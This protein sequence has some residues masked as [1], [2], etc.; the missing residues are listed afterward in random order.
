MSRVESEFATR[1]TEARRRRG[2][3]PGRV[4]AECARLG[5]DALDATAIAAIETGARGVTAAE[6]S[7]LALALGVPVADLVPTPLPGPRPPVR[8]PRP[9]RSGPVDFFISYSLLDD[10]WATWIAHE[11]ESAGYEVM[12]Q[13]WDFVPGTHFLDF[14]DRGIRESSAVIAVLSSNYLASQYGRLEWMAAMQAAHDRPD[15]KLLLPVR[16]Q[17]IFP[18]GLLGQVTFVDLVGIDEPSLARA[19][20]LDRLEHALTGRAK[21]GEHPRFPGAAVV[22]ESIPAPRASQQDDHAASEFPPA[23]KPTGSPRHEL[24]IL[25][26]PGP[27]FGRDSGSPVDRLAALDAGLARLAESGLPT[28][29]LVV[30]SG[31]LTDSGSREQFDQVRSFLI[32]LRSLLG[33]DAGRLVVVPGGGDITAAACE[34]YFAHCRAESLNPEPPYFSKWLHYERLHRELYPGGNGTVFD[35]NQPW[36]LVEVA[37][38]R[39]VVAAFNSTVPHTHQN[40]DQ[41]GRLGADQLAWF[42]A[43]L[44]PFVESGHLRIGVVGHTP[45]AEG[46]AALADAAALDNALGSRLNLLLSGDGPGS[47]EVGALA[48]G[49]TLVPP[50]GGPR[51]LHLTRDGVD[52]W[53]LVDG[54]RRVG[55]ARGPWHAAAQTFTPPA[56][57]GPRVR[58]NRVRPADEA[59]SEQ[60]VDQLLRRI[61]EVLEVRHPGAAVRRLPGRPP[62]LRVSYPDGDLVPQFLIAAHVGEPTAAD[63]AALATVR[64]RNAEDLTSELVYQGPNPGVTLRAAALRDGIRLRSFIEFQGL[65]DLRGYVKAQTERLR[66]DRVYPPELYVPQRFR[67]TEGAAAS[68]AGVRED[69]VGELVD[70]LAAD[71]GRF[72]LLM[73]D[74]GRGKTF[75]MRT[76]AMTLPAKLPGVSPIL[77]ELHALD[78]AHSVDGLVAAHL[79][80]HGESRID[81]RAFRYL[82]RQG[83]VVLLF[84]GFDE[85]ASRVS[86][87]RA[88]EH[89]TTLLAAA[90]DRAKIVVTS[91]TQHFQNDDQVRTALGQQVGALAQRRILL[92]EDFT[93]QQVDAYVANRYANDEEVARERIELINRVDDLGGLSRNPRMLSF[94]VGLDAERLAAVAARDT[95][96]AASLYEEIL[97]SWLTHEHDRA[98]P[99]G[100]QAGLTLPEMWSAVTTLA[101]R[102]WES[103]DVLLRLDDVAEV[104]EALAGLAEAP[105]SPQ[106]ATH[107]VGA[108]SLLVRT[109][110]GLFGFIHSSVAEYLLAREIA[111]QLATGDG[112]PALLGRRKLSQPTVDFLCDLA[113]PRRLLLWAARPGGDPVTAANALKISKRLSAPAKTDMREA[114]LRGEDLSQRDLSGV[115]LT[116]ADLT[117][118]LLIGTKLSRA[119]L[120][121]AR[122]HRTRLDQAVLRDADLTDADLTGARLVETDLRGAVVTGSTWARAAL[123]NVDADRELWAAPEL[124]AAAVAPGQPVLTGLRPA[125]V[126]VQFGFE[127]GRLPSPLAYSPDGSL[128]AVGSGDGGVLLCDTEKGLPLRTLNGHLDRVYAVDFGPPGSALVTAAADG[129]VRFWDPATGEQTKVV[130]DGVEHTAP[131]WPLLISPDGGLVAY[132]DNAGTVVVRTVPAGEVVHRFDGHV[133]RVWALAFHPTDP[134]LATADESGAVRLWDL[135]TGAER[136]VLASPGSAVYTLSF[137]ADGRL[138]A[139]AGQ[140]AY[141]RVWDVQ[142]GAEAHRL[143]GHTE[144]VYAAVF[145]PEHDVLASGDTAGSVR[146][147]TVPRH[148]RATGAPLQHRHATAVYHLAFSPDGRTLAS[149]DSDG[150]LRVWDTASGQETHEV[151]AH[152][153]AV[154]P[155]A[156][157]ADSAQ[158]A[159]TGRDGAI[160]LWDPA[161]GRQRHELHGHGRRVV[162]VHF[163]RDGDLLAAAGNDG[164]VRVWDPGTGR[165]LRVL[166]GR[167]DQLTG[168]VFNPVRP[169][170][171]T[172]SNDGGVHL[173]HLSTW[174]ADQEL[175]VETEYVWA[176]AF[177]PDGEVLAT[178]NDDDTVRLWWQATGR[179]VLALLEHRGRVRSIVFSPDGSLV[180]TGCDD[181]KVRLFDRET[182]A[183]LATLDGHTDRV[184]DVRFTADGRLLASV[185]NDGTAVLW[186]VADHAR[187]RVLPA[188]RGKLWCCAFSPDGRVLA[189]AGD[190]A[191]IYL[192]DTET[193]TSLARMPGHS[194]RVLSLAFSP[195]GT[196]LASGSA[197]G[198][199]RLWNI[200]RRT[201]G[202]TMIGLPEAWAAVTPDGRYK[203]DGPPSGE[204]WHAV[205]LCRFEVGEL[206]TVLREVR[207]VP[208][209]E[210][211]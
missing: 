111:R 23:T 22:K 24:G 120:R 199:T 177:A 6:V 201:L 19:R 174:R 179:E 193:G 182:G 62:V 109:E 68:D 51:L 198:T 165:Q 140:H 3:S 97:T 209:T 164:V 154:W 116:G 137:N 64:R 190:D 12:I 166:T 181:T 83:R 15:Q 176:S 74:F 91:R 4:A 14:I 34:A 102:V 11:L 59:P 31:S 115:D 150:T 73:G 178:A 110:D 169:L 32:G 85:L 107:A 146:L 71:E 2:W 168:A 13:A 18:D 149:G 121:G 211:F 28:P 104:A 162:Q 161:T 156:F 43:A 125:S 72:V 98:N 58:Q 147:W 138:L 96:S 57:A 200:P 69:V 113:E 122:L 81:L 38:L 160:R 55:R 155:L 9:P 86:Y 163:N 1:V 133:E 203:V 141:L 60:P 126:G 52:T 20:L 196:T 186:R 63:V 183:C 204:F 17:N 127:D 144:H 208:L 27:R 56:G 129:T 40:L 185:S 175:D 53:S 41:P 152:R 197:D 135:D 139:A 50:A 46:S 112:R 94:V 39:V 206:D 79:A 191:V 130:A 100:S 128:L 90:E 172:P 89:L 148:G 36:S 25:H 67:E 49:L 37:D 184:Y 105:L 131:I 21:P 77:I 33:I 132:G 118:A 167:D 159:T 205:G 151:L 5:S 106:Q 180:A 158:L 117:D 88:A 87:D 44:A 75:A 84:D 48:G 114:V 26:V 61:T 103:N 10:A 142:S 173:W 8:G 47:A 170:L 108:G 99:P 123:I 16:I 82:L 42:G 143:D 207:A 95:I 202:L 80:N 171:A 66:Q 153:G 157:R 119:V 136:H 188:Q 7:L 145:H 187:L 124:R 45:G 101:L 189:A 30:V 195:D 93:D 194:R 29:E 76:L 92:L 78:K 192:W 54:P 35:A 65:L 70:L 134:L 210:P